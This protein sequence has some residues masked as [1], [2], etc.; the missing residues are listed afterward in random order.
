MEIGFSAYSGFEFLGFYG[1]LIVAAVVAGFWIPG[2]L[3]P[4]GETRRV[5][6][7]EELAYLAGGPTRLADCV[8]AKLMASGSLRVNGK[9]VVPTGTGAG[10]TKAERALLGGYAPFGQAVALRNLAPHS[11]AIESSLERQGLL[12]DQSDRILLR[13]LPVIPYL[14]V[15]AIGLFRWQA[16]RTE[17][18]PVGYLTMMLIV[19]AIFTLLRLVRFNP[20][21]KSGNR[22]LDD[23]QANAQRMRTAPTRSE[24]G[25]AVGLFGTAV[26]AGTPYA[27]LHAMRPNNA[28]GSGGGCGGGS[29]CG[30]GGCGG[31]GG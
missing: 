7:A 20:R 10:D 16:G 23:A 31:C 21:T 8:M 2:W 28:D 17:G 6:D 14:T 25:M 15:L 27:S 4:D 30:G 1:L 12:V 3:R 18:E 11:D 9:K 22:A 5:D 13:V 26:L 24:T 29:G 19:V